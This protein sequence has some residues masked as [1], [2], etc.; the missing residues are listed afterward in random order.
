MLMCRVHH[1]LVHEGGWT[2]EWSGRG[3][4]RSAAFRDPRGI[5]HVG[6]PPAAPELSLD[7]EREPGD[8]RDEGHASDDRNLMDALLKQGVLDGVDQ[9]PDALTACATWKRETDIPDSVLFPA[10]ETL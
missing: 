6:R 1:R 8:G 10:L 7:R 4:P 5:L 2:V 9:P 3:G